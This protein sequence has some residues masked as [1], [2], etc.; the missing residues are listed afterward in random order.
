MKPRYK[1]PRYKK[2]QLAVCRCG[3][4][5][6]VKLKIVQNFMAVLSVEDVLKILTYNLLQKRKNDRN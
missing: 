1:K 6:S 4:V 3:Y 2:P 5:M